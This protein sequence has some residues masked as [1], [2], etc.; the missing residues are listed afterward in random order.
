MKTFELKTV[1]QNT[2]VI[3]VKESIASLKQAINSVDNEDQTLSKSVNDTSQNYQ[4]ALVKKGLGKINNN[5]FA[6]IESSMKE[7]RDKLQKFN[8]ENN[9]VV[10]GVKKQA[11]A[12]LEEELKLAEELAATEICNEVDSYIEELRLELQD[13]V[14]KIKESLR[15]FKKVLE[16]KRRLSPS[17]TLVFRYE[18]PHNNL[19]KVHNY[20]KIVE[21]IGKEI[22]Q[23]TL[24]RIEN[25]REFIQ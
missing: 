7:A 17:S 2:N 25:S 15:E 11:L 3:K 16:I 1:D 12:K 14:N 21:L 19:A 4:D 8:G 13:P 18:Y 6:E 9:P 22:P 5:Q 23:E 10:R 20:L 24:F